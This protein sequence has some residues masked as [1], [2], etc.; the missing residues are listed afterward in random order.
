M[1]VVKSICRWLS[2]GLIALV[3]SCVTFSCVIL[4]Y[5]VFDLHRPL[6]LD[7]DVCWLA[8]LLGPTLI[9]VIHR[10][11]HGRVWVP[12]VTLLGGLALSGFGVFRFLSARAAPPTHS[13][14]LAKLADD[15]PMLLAL[16]MVLLAALA[17]LGAILAL[18]ARRI[19]GSAE[20]AYVSPAAGDPPAHP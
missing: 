18:L 17:V 10:G 1:K 8:F 12:V 15:M 3:V 7:D 5:E 16:L 11:L 19:G 14:P 2:S 13:G 9:V 6:G 20:P 4:A